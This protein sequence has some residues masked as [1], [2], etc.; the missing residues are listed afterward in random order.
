MRT[1]NHC[2]VFILFLSIL[3]LSSSC[4]PELSTSQQTITIMTY[5]ILD[6]GGIG[7]TDPTGPWCAGYKKVDEHGNLAAVSGGFPLG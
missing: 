1:L 4:S 3:L 2:V 5:N 7:P 6:G